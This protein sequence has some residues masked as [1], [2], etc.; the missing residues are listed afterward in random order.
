MANTPELT[1]L[2]DGKCSLCRASVARIQR[3]DRDHRIEM[4]DLHDAAATARFPQVDREAAF[5][6]MQAVRAD[7]RVSTGVN[8][9]AEIGELLPG[10]KWISWLLLVP[11]IHWTAT[12]LYG[13][14]ARNRYRWNAAACADGSC[15]IHLPSG[16]SQKT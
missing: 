16:S 4:L 11:G 5:R 15:K 6:L 10:W 3:F 1:V 7:G 9:Y 14:V 2:Y 13:W 12:K 8:A